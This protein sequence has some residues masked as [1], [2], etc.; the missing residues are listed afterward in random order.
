MK[1]LPGPK[2]LVL[3]L[4]LSFGNCV[5]SREGGPG[6]PQE[7]DTRT[8]AITVTV[9]GRS[10]GIYNHP[11]IWLTPSRLDRLKAKAVSSNPMWVGLDYTNGRQLSEGTYKTAADSTALLNFAVGYLA[12]GKGDYL[13]AAKA[14]FA[15]FPSK[16]NLSCDGSAYCGNSYLDFGSFDLI[17]LA[18]AY[19]WLAY[20]L[21]DSEKTAIRDWVFTKF[22]PFL[23]LHP[24]YYNGAA[25]SHYYASPVHNL[26][27][28]KWIGEFLWS[29]ATVGDDPR[30]DAIL[31]QQFTFWRDRISPIFD[32]YYP[33]GHSYGGS[34]YGYNRSYKFALYGMEALKTGTTV[35]GYDGHPWAKDDIIFR[36]HSVLPSQTIFHSDWESAEAFFNQGRMTENEALIVRRFQGTTEAKFGQ[37]F[38]NNVFKLR[39]YANQGGNRVHPYYVGFW[40]LW[41]DPEDEAVS[42]FDQPTAYVASGLGVGFSRTGWTDTA[43]AWTS[44]SS[45]P[46]VG[47]HQLHNEGSFKIWRNGEYLVIEN[48]RCYAANINKA[49]DT[50]ASPMFANIL[51]LNGDTHTGGLGDRGDQTQAS[52]PRFSQGSTYAYFLGDLTKAYLPVGALGMFHRTYVH[53]KATTGS[54]DFFVVGDRFSGGG[55]K[56]QQIF[57][58][59]VPTIAGADASFTTSGNRL[60]I[61][62]ILPASGVT[63][64]SPASTENNTATCLTQEASD[65][66][67]LV[68]ISIPGTANDLLLTVLHAGGPTSTMP[69]TDALT[70]DD[71]KMSGVLIKATLNRVYLMGT[72]SGQVS[73]A[74]SVAVNSTPSAEFVVGDLPPNQKYDV[75]QPSGKVLL[76]PNDSGASAADASGVLRF[77]L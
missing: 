33:G 73:G 19:D 39:A 10:V 48:G 34:G 25:G 55:S 76:T 46:Y 72:T 17:N 14:L 3:V 38:L 59:A 40:Y 28:T 43:S 61:R 18:A 62:S 2:I 4:F 53:F 31:D 71:G 63:L 47:D 44:F 16:Y 51:Q 37:Y 8:P 42:Y 1:Y 36:I 30:A 32:K 64:S 70:S 35:D 9:G 24:Y 12:G 23:R 5:C 66:P 21:S 20:D 15:N 56:T 58:P 22:I 68:R 27:H 52:I 67:T 7:S 45:A 65:V 11:R 77:T 50:N 60:D 75:T 26:T 41:Y 29:L 69:A 57:L 6:R 13:T 49:G 54:D 74:I